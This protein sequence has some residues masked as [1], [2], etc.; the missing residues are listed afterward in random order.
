MIFVSV[1]PP[2]RFG[3]WCDAATAY[4][5][6][7]SL[8]EVASVGANTLEEFAVGV[9]QAQAPYIVVGSRQTTGKLWEA[10]RQSARGFIVAVEHP[11]RALEHMVVDQ[12]IDFLEA[13]HVAARSCAAVASS[14]PLP[15]AL[16][17]RA[18]VGLDAMAMAGSIA[19][20][21][22]LEIGEDGIADIVQH[23]GG[24]DPPGEGEPSSSWWEGLEEQQRAIANGA[25]EPFATHLAGANLGPITWQRDLFFMDE[26]QPGGKHQPAARPVDITGRPR[27]IIY[28]PYLSLPPG[29]WSAAVALGFSPE[30]GDMSYLVEVHSGALL[31]QQRIQPGGQRSVEVTLNFSIAAPDLVEVRVLNERAAFDGRLALGHVIVTPHA[32]MRPET[33]NFFATALT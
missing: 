27:Y 6:R 1:G 9:M 21:L 12:G 3:E 5:V 2:S 26:E 13:V 4:L 28:G 20:F 15:G 18:A 17:L 30:A 23:L 25:L 16:T 14:L 19:N 29:S 8:G 31:A 11:R 22:G 7:R 32:S 10:L 33:Q 24:A